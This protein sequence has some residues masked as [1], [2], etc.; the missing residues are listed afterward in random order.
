MPLRRNASLSLMLWPKSVVKRL[1]P[2]LP[3]GRDLSGWVELRLFR[4]AID[5]A[6]A[7]AAAK[8]QRIGALY[9]STRSTL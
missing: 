7:A 1:V 3:P 8:R 4:D 2:K 9:A 6:T 5:D